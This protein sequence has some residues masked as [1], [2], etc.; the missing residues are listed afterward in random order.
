MEPETGHHEAGHSSVHAHE[1]TD[2]GVHAAGILGGAFIILLIFG[3]VT[4]YLAFRF[5]DSPESVGPPASPL[6][7]GRVIPKGPRLQ[8]NADDDLVDYLD[9]E[10][11]ALDSYGWLDQKAGVVRVPID[12]AMDVVLKNGLPVRGAEP[13]GKAGGRSTASLASTSAAP[14]SAAVQ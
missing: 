6:S 12:Q 2:A 8:V 10:Q 3:I 7:S 13:Q 11:Q 9:R 1:K 5:F 4:G 14:R